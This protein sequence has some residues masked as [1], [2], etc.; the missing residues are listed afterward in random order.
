MLLP[1][2]KEV[3]FQETKT[4]SKDNVIIKPDNFQC[5]TANSREY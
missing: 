1:M 3:Q 4:V 5:N 2:T